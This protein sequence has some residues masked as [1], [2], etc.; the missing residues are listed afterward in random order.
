M[1]DTVSYGPI[2][3]NGDSIEDT[4]IDNLPNL[5]CDLSGFTI[6]RWDLQ[7]DTPR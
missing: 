3:F 2:F 7:C 1:Y 4:D 5:K 6:R